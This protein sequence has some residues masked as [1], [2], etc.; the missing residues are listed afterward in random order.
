MTSYVENETDEQF[1]FDIKKIL[2]DV[3][4]EALR[5]EACPYEAQVN[6]LI[7]D[8][9]GIREYNKQYR[10]IDSPTD[11]LSF[12]MISFASEADFS[13]VEE[14]EADYFDPE[15]GELILGDIIISADKV[16][17]QAVK[18]GH[19]EKREFAFL[20]A[21]SLLHLCGYDHITEEEAKVMEQKQEEILNRLSITRDNQ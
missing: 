13:I 19:S 7:T 15:S 3:F 20:V 5:Q 12:P 21:H 4:N 16:K 9:E 2:D 1:N 8:N 11:V 10:D 18:F 6:L 17:E 14:Q